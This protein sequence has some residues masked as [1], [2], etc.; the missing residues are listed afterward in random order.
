MPQGVDK[1]RNL[2]KFNIIV[3]LLSIFNR[4][5]IGQYYK[6]V[7]G[8]KAAREGKRVVIQPRNYID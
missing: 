5:T 4:L 8:T 1:R 2:I 6:I 3:A 7:A